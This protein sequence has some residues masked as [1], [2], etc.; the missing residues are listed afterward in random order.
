MLPAVGVRNEHRDRRIERRRIVANGR[1][2]V[3]RGLAARGRRETALGRHRLCPCRTAGAGTGRSRRASSAM[4][5]SI[6][7]R[8]HGTG[9]RSGPAASA[10]LL[11][12]EDSRRHGYASIALNAAIQTMKA[13]RRYRFRAAVLRTAQCAVLR[14]TR[15]E[16]VRRRDLCRT[17][18][19]AS[20]LRGYR[21]LCLRHQARA[22]AGYHRPM[23]SAL[24]TMHGRGVASVS[25]SS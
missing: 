11:T 24:V 4:S 20:S 14:R 19:G 25:A 21:A 15:L 7:A 3:Q 9:A 18:A 10:A 22:A 17:T 13:R 2:A 8:S 12:R 16:A 5:A 23:R 6:A 1:T